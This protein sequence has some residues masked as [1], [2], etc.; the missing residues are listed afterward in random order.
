MAFWGLDAAVGI[1]LPVSV[2]TSGWLVVVAA[3]VLASV[4]AD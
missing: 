1:W 2:V 3:I 4:E